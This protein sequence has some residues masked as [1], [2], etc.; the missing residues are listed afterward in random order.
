VRVIDETA[1]VLT[2]I[3]LLAVAGGK[4][5]TSPFVVT[6]VGVKQDDNWQLASL[7]FTRLNK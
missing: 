2:T 6:E 3:D 5:V 1:I 7:S 4:V